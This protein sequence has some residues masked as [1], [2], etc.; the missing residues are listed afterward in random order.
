MVF[1]N[2]IQMKS[3]PCLTLKAIALIIQ[4]FGERE[5]ERFEGGFINLNS[6]FPSSS[7]PS[8]K[9]LFG[10]FDFISLHYF[11]FRN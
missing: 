1:N 3:L 10:S 5:R 6:W 11:F 8:P 9:S 4:N 2:H 7:F